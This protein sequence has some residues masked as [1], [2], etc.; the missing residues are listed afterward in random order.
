MSTEC[1][2]PGRLFGRSR[3]ERRSDFVWR[4]HSIQRRTETASPA[5]RSG[6]GKGAAGERQL[7]GDR[8]LEHRACGGTQRNSAVFS[9]RLC[10]DGG[11]NTAAP[12]S[13]W[14]FGCVQSALALS[15]D[16]RGDSSPSPPG[17]AG[18]REGRAYASFERRRFRP[19]RCRASSMLGRCSRGNTLVAPNA[20]PGLGKA[21][22]LHTRRLRAPKGSL[23]RSRRRT[24]RR[25]FER[26]VC[27]TRQAL[28]VT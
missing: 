15:S 11:G 5:C 19:V 7:S 1:A 22:Q 17:G 4:S 23:T 9:R 2:V 12:Y 26:A 14:L 6:Q 10:R 16:G 20:T 3:A 18:G 25:R 28:R 8:Q 27:Q 24:R 13:M 21:R